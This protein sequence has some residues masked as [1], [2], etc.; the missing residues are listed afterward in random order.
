MYREFNII[1]LL[2][3]EKTLADRIKR[4]LELLA[5]ART[6]FSSERSLLAWIRT[7]VSLITFGFSIM[8]FFDYLEQQQQGEQSSDSPYQLGIALMLVGTLTLTPAVI[9]HVQ[10]LRKMKELGL[11]VKSRLSLP[12]VAAVALFGIGVI[13]LIGSFLNWST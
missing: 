5:L 11:P 13:T 7:S 6:A 4:H 3:D 10:R 1:N 8:K 9:E 12:I 2:E